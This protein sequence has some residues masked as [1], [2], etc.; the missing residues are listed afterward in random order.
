MLTEVLEIN[1][2]ILYFVYG[3]VFFIMG[4]VTGL[5]W[6]RHSHLELA[7]PLP[8]LAAFGIAHGLNEW[9]Y[10]FIPLQ[11]LYLKDVVVQLM[12]VAH[13]L[14]LAVSYFCLFQFGVE[15]VL[16]LLPRFRWLRAVPGA[17]LVLWA[18]AVF[19][20][21]AVVQ[22]PLRVLFAIG[23]GW[24]R[25]LL[26]LPGATLAGLGLLR[27]ARQVRE[28]GLPRIA[29]YLN[30][31]AVAFLVY[32]LAGGLIVP[33]APVFPATHLNY[34]LLE[35]TIRIPVAVFRSV[36]G[37]AMAFFVV[38]SLEIFQ[39]EDDRRIAEM[40]RQQALVADRERIGRELHDGII[41][42][43]YASGLTL[44]DTQHLV[45]E[46]PTLAQHR[47][48]T[49]MDA[50]NRTI[51]DIRRYIYDLRAAEQSREL[52]VVLEDLVQELRL[53]IMLD[54]ELEVQGQRCCWMSEQQVGHIT[55]IA[56]EALSNVVQH[57]GATHVV[58]SL[59]YNGDTT[60]LTVEDDGR[61]IP[62]DPQ[63]SEGHGGQGVANMQAR[64]RMLGGELIMNCAQ[65]GGLCLR[66]IVPCDGAKDLESAGEMEEGWA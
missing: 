5:Q 36:C 32:A 46:N 7:R 38:R 31:A 47:I 62:A 8:W 59:G 29:N 41:Q 11:A 12:I 6:R 16:P 21:G 50:L 61:G 55:Q 27:Q 30:G 58:V 22:E 18:M 39:V 37:L 54:V 64:A 45:L 15:L 44:E 2:I 25:Y 43:I 17:V 66:L 23:E 53:D 42:N 19:L 49:V 51:L 56:R 60:S 14:L 63:T 65:G 33:T 48:T 35:R 20:R 9:G 40:E 52:E 24:A 13:L 1:W 4:L 26:C 10:I 34:A 28:F 57:S 3:Q